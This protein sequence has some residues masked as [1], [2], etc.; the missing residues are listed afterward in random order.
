MTQARING[1][2]IEYEIEGAEQGDPLLLIM[3]LG[4]QMTRWPPELRH[5]LVDKGFRVIRFDNRD[6]GLSQKFKGAPQIADVV[7]ALN[8]GAKPDIP[9]TLDDM[10]ADA[11]GVLDHLG[12]KR[13]HIVGASMGGM[14]AQLMVADNPERARS[15]TII[16]SSTGNPALPPATPEAMAVITTRAPDP[17]AQLDAYLDQMVKNARTIASPGYAFDEQGVREPARIDVKRCYEPLGVARQMAA[18]VASGDR[19]AKIKAISTPTV[20]LHGDADPLVPLE[21]GRDIAAAIADAELR[22]VPG[23]GH[24]IPA[25]LYDVVVDAIA[26][27]AERSRAL[28]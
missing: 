15:L 26:R 12:I 4:A 2:A 5:K 8:R 13:A 3:G 23:M 28:A 11:I 19:R 7:G 25:A 10:A 9:Y 20:V 18:V 22:V 27:A 21:G 1:I 6:V 24:D 16:F 17:N 14:I